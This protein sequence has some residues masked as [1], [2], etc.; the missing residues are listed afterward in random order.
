MCDRFDRIDRSGQLADLL[1]PIRLKF[2]PASETDRTGQLIPSMLR[3]LDQFGSVDLEAE[4]NNVRWKT[5]SGH[6]RVVDFLV[7]NFS[8]L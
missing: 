1:R 7:Q 4:H 6:H 5:G 3:W 8:E 2:D